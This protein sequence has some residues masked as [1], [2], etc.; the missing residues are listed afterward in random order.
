M[1]HLSP[2]Q[3]VDFRAEIERQ[4]VRLEK[5]M[6]VSDEAT[7][8]VELDQAA[9]GRLSR[10]DS[11]QNQSMA[12]NLAERERARHAQLRAALERIDAGTYGVCD[13]CGGPIAPGRLFVF[14]ETITCGGCG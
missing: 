2:D 13:D 9:V 12:T 1:S 5:S 10:M 4:I 7:A 3:I 14:P 8:T 11:L 6:A